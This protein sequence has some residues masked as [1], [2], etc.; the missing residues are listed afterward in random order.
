MFTVI[1]PTQNFMDTT[2]FNIPQRLQVIYVNEDGEDEILEDYIR[3]GP[4][5][6]GG[7][8]AFY[9]ISSVNYLQYRFNL[10][11]TIQQAISTQNSNFK[12]RIS[13]VRS[14]LP[15]IHRTTIAGATS[16]NAAQRMKLN[17]IYTK[18]Q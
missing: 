10:S 7:F 1:S 11:H 9:N 16:A 2:N 8:R 15:G 6:V 14:N 18:I 4:T 5:W 13:G 3:L 17:I 12:F